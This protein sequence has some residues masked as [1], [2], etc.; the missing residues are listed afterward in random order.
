[1]DESTEQHVEHD[2]CGRHISGSI[3]GGVVKYVRRLHGDE[4]VQRL[5]EL[6]GE[7]RSIA[8]IEDTTSWSSYHQAL[9]L[10]SA[11]VEVTGDPEVSRR[12]GED[13][14]SQYAGTEVAALLRSLGSPG[15]LLRNVAATA[16]KYSTVSAMEAIEV[17][18][19]H[20]LLRSC[21]APPHRRHPL[22]CLYTMGLLSQVSPL[23][24]L[25]PAEVTELECQTRGA[26]ACLYEVRWGQADTSDGSRRADQ[27]AAQ[28]S[29]LTQR[30][31]ALQATAS[32]FIAA[33][34][35]EDVLATITR[36]AGLAVRAPQFLLAV[37]LDD[38]EELR[39]HHTGFDD[40]DAAAAMASQLVDGKLH[41]ASSH[42]VVDIASGNRRFGVLA[43]IYPEG[44]QFFAQERQMLAAY[45][46]FAA[47]ALQATWSL[48][49]ARRQN[50]TARA[51]LHLGRS[52]ARVLTTD[53]V[54]AHLAEAIPP[55][56]QCPTATVMLWEPEREV[57][58]LRGSHGLRPE[59]ARAVE[60]LE[61]GHDDTPALR[62][63]L[64]APA[65]VFF[66]TTTPD[67]FLR[68]ILDIALIPAAAVVPITSHGEFLGTV[69]VGR[70]TGCPP[71]PDFVERLTGM[72]DQAATALLNGRLLETVR[73]QA[74]HDNL[75]GLPNT[76]LLADRA[77]TAIAQATRNGTLA[78]LLFI[79]L[80][81]FKPVNDTYGHAAGD[82][83]LQTTA[84]RLL[85]TLRAGDTV[86]RL[87]GDEFVVLLP[88]I[89]ELGDAAAAAARVVR[90]LDRPHDIGGRPVT[91]SSSVGVAIY[92]DHGG[93]FESLLRHADQAMYAAKATGPGTFHLLDS[94]GG[95]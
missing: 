23:F 35:V 53:E 84:A 49:E 74:L 72:A 12:I 55:V 41:H 64:E 19:D 2:V 71:D 67:P 86:A 31:E 60:G 21:T 17:E 50:T 82:L 36:R 58:R 42:L 32:Q 47:A 94:P 89:D 68:A 90:A 4:G 43:A 88:Q 83:V 76:R 93:C 52:L 73:Q 5:L 56:V 39:V 51:L 1:M 6:A 61:I 15:A 11:A 85:K 20:A 54:V 44:H 24:G 27:L 46:G 26:P 33:E 8:E 10:Y 69:V 95:C 65:P 87:G 48:T 13:A 78:G 66:D 7:T 92:P 34:G 29:S 18:D 75:T 80:D 28:L 79:D 38:G 37:R 77:S 16:S 40:D 22:F 3:T 59:V 57:L 45:G 9:A 14:L 70:Q 91:V 62:R 30:F 81:Q 25:E 63:M